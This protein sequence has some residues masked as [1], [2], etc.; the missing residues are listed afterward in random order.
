MKFHQTTLL[1]TSLLIITLPFSVSAQFTAAVPFAGTSSGDLI[2][3]ITKIVN[4]FLSLVAMVAVIVIIFGTASAIGAGD[5][6]D[7]AAR[8]KNNIIYALLGLV[9]VGLSAVIVNFLLAVI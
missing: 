7:V 6:E 9:I 8:A 1:F 2:D 3:T 5:Q 4:A